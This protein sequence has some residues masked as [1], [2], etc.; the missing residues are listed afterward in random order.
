MKKNE[1]MSHKKNN[2]KEKTVEVGMVCYEGK[3]KIGS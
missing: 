3:K 1:K 2:K